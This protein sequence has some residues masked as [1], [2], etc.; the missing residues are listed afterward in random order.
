MNIDDIYKSNSKF[1]KASD[2]VVDEWWQNQPFTLHLQ[3]FQGNCDLCFKKS[4]KKLVR[5]INK[6]PERLEWWKR[7]EKE[8]SIP[9]HG[10]R[11]AKIE[12]S[13]FF[14]GNMNSVELGELAVEAGKQRELFDGLDETE[15]DCQCKSS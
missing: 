2:L 6:E 15:T 1:L 10:N 7:M 5:A 12:P 4:T 14:R 9:S 13:Y 3:D 11:S 8:H